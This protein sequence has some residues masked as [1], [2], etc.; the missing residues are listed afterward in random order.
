MWCSRGKADIRK[1][2]SGQIIIGSP[3]RSTGYVMIII[4]LVVDPMRHIIHR[5][6]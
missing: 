3:Y 6:S 5:S 1:V 4:F 2:P